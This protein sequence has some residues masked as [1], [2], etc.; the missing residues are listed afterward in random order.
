[1][2]HKNF[3]RIWLPV[4]IVTL[5]LESVGHM[6]T[7]SSLQANGLV[8]WS[9]NMT[10]AAWVGPL[11]GAFAA[12]LAFTYIFLQGYTGRGIGEG[13]RFGLWATLLASVPWVLGLSSSLPIGRRIPCEFIFI[14]LVTLVAAGITAAWLAGSGSAAKSAS[15]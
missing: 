6:L 10:S 4:F 1:M 3:G 5:V 11:V 8:P 15:A 14:D 12:S 7:R 9:L 13:I 2:R